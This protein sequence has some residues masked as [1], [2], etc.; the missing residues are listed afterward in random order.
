MLS[1][2]LLSEKLFKPLKVNTCEDFTWKVL[3]R[4]K[5]YLRD[6]NEFHPKSS[7]RMSRLCTRRSEYIHE[8]SSYKL[9]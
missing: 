6:D 2:V 9:H 8:I 4:P 7:N 1:P 3:T 5:Y